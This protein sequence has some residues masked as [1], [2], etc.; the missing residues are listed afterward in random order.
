MVSGTVRNKSSSFSSDKLF[1]SL[2]DYIN[3]TN[4]LLTPHEVCDCFHDRRLA[5]DKEM[6]S[7]NRYFYDAEYNNTLVYIQAL[8]TSRPMRGR[9]ESGSVFQNF[10]NLQGIP[11]STVMANRS[12]N[13]TAN[14]PSENETSVSWEWEEWSDL[15]RHV[16]APIKPDSVVMNA[17]LWQ[18][19]FLDNKEAI[20][21]LEDALEE[22]EIKRWFWRTTSYKQGGHSRQSNIDTDAKMC[23]RLPCIDLSWSKRVKWTYHSDPVHFWEPFYRIS[24]EQ[25]LRALGALPE[26]YVSL[27]RETIMKPIRNSEK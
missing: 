4:Q 1:D 15:I 11:S 16:V 5:Q 9:L 7:S 19:N 13:V 18:N 20:K 22:S 12:E 17:G 6:W 2:K 14:T 26:E 8:G 23:G 10:D 3:F 25:T 27:S 21:N 24:N